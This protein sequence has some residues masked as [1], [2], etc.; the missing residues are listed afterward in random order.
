M[1]LRPPISTRTDTLFPYTT[2]FRSF[3]P[4]FIA[5]RKLQIV[6]HKITTIM[7]DTA[8]ENIQG[9]WDN[10]MASAIAWAPRIITAV[11]SAL[12]IYLIGLWLIRLIKRFTAKA[13][14][15]STRLNSSH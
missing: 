8:M 5:L 11:I 4:L 2:L 7:Q 3:Y 6:N 1:I 15:K 12:L 13:D 14:R 9:Q 10:L